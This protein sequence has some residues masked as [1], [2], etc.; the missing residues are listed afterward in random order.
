MTIYAIYS[1]P[2]AGPEAIAA[3]PERFFWS[4]FLVTPFWALKNRSWA[5]FLLWLVVA[6]ALGAAHGV[7]G[8][9]AVTAL[10]GLFALWS[11]F[12]APAVAARALERRGYMAHGDLAAPDLETAERAWLERLYG[13]RA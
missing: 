7:I 5:F 1:K 4:A 12:A 13:E 8:T 6:V 9:G 3:V 11:G 2:D 10:Y